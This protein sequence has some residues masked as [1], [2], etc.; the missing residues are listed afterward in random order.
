LL[1]VFDTAVVDTIYIVVGKV[2]L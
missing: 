2:K 1:K